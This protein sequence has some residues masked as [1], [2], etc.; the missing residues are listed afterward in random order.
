MLLH[1]G[2]R[3]VRLAEAW[4]EHKHEFHIEN[5]HAFEASGSE[6]DY[7][8]QRTQTYANMPQ[9]VELRGQVH[10]GNLHQLISDIGQMIQHI[11]AQ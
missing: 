8:G 7:E 5:V 3:L 10:V 11:A 4:L 9:Q 2:G 1:N 6:I